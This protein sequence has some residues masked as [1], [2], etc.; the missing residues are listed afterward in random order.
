MRRPSQDALAALLIGIA[1][2]AYLG[3]GLGY[4]LGTLARPGSGF[5]PLV[6]GLAGLG[7]A[8]LCV[9]RADPSRRLDPGPKAVA[10]ALALLAFAALLEP[11]G[12]IPAGAVF[13][14]LT[15][16]LIGSRSPRQVIAMAV[17]APVATYVVFAEAFGVVLPKGIVGW[18]F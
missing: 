18:I 5:F 4:R 10:F 8:G 17:V 15:A 9:L 12:F 11:V 6:L 14:A 13:T 16:R 3:V 2:A 1:T 7:L